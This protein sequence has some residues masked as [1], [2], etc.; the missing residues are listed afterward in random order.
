M[1]N[2]SA[3]AVPRL[4]AT[5]P[6]DVLA[7][8]AALLGF[9]PVESVVVVALESSI[10]QFACRLDVGWFADDEPGVA[11]MQA[12]LRQFPDVRLMLLGYSQHT[13]L[14]RHSLA[15]L[16]LLL[17][18]YPVID[19]L[20]TDERRWWSLLCHDECCPPEGR[21]YDFAATALASQAVFEG[22]DISCD[23]DDIVTAVAGPGE[24]DLD[25]LNET[26]LAVAR[27]VAALLPRQRF[28]EALDV[29]DAFRAQR[30]TLTTDEI[31]RL[32][33]ELDSED[34]WPV[35]LMSVRRHDAASFV[36]LFRQLVA[37]CVPD[38]AATVVGLLGMVA[39][40]A[41]GGALMTACAQRLELLEPCHP[42]FLMLLEIRQDGLPPSRWGPAD[43]R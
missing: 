22:I 18:D 4:R 28:S 8:A 37:G 11:E 34:V 13:W 30:W 43:A 42:L 33:I 39:W 16:H 41:G 6:S 12:A 21:P 17:C 9:R 2:T 3:T 35:V 19:V 32:C 23:R 31:A 7:S 29:I 26:F 40:L 14:V 24:P 5:S 15:Q 10:I 1:N 36:D 20:H 25:A 38:F 27:R